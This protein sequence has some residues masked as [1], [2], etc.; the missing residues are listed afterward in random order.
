MACPWNRPVALSCCEAGCAALA[1]DWPKQNFDCGPPSWSLTLDPP[2]GLVP[3]AAARTHLGETRL[4]APWRWPLTQLFRTLLRAVLEEEY[5]RRLSRVN[6]G[7]CTADC[8]SR[9]SVTGPAAMYRPKARR[10]LER[11]ARG[12]LGPTLSFSGVCQSRR[13]IVFADACS[14]DAGGWQVPVCD[15]GLTPTGC[16]SQQ[17][18][19]LPRTSGGC[20]CKGVSGAGHSVC[21]V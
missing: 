5:R 20:S 3:Q 12:V 14:W 7:H 8:C 11:S 21:C 10:S 1:H 19:H 4:T 16:T 15:S 6:P 9:D 2:S 13:E 18:F 17:R